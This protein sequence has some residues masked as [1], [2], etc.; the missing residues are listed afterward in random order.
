MSTPN[1]HAVNS[2]TPKIRA[3]TIPMQRVVNRMMRGL[4]RTP[5]LCRV[6]GK[7]LLTVY[8][9]GRKSG[10]EYVVPLAYTRHDGVL[11]VGTQ[12]AWGRNLRTGEPVVIRLAGKRRRANVQVLTDEQGVVEHFAVMCRGN[13]QFAKLNQIGFDTAGNP[14]RADLRLAWAAGARAIRLTVD[15]QD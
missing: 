7:R 6:V 10:R 5:L 3:Q 13:A 11:L 4:L 15:Q 9:V 2:Q 14:S 8:A 1:L 12:F